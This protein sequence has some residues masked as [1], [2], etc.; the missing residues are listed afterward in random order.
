MVVAQ[1]A[2]KK[3]L[4]TMFFE[5]DVADESFYKDEVLQSRL[6]AMLETIDVQRARI[7]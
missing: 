7:A 1:M 5:G 2:Q 6:E 3:G 4:Q